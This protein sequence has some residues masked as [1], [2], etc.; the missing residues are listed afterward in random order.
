MSCFVAGAGNGFGWANVLA[1]WAEDA[2]VVDAW[3]GP[4]LLSFIQRARFE[5]EFAPFPFVWNP[6]GLE[7]GHNSR[8]RVL[9]HDLC[10]AAFSTLENFFEGIS[11]R[12]VWAAVLESVQTVRVLPIDARGC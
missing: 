12:R 4:V 11:S 10:E 7:R 8:D 1:D 9:W 3:N 5:R 2:V 6:W